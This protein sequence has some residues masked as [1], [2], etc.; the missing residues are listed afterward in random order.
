[1][2]FVGD[3]YNVSMNSRTTITLE[4]DSTYSAEDTMCL[5]EMGKSLGTW[6]LVA[7][8]TIKFHNIS[9]SGRWENGLEP[10]LIIETE[11]EAKKLISLLPIS[12]LQNHNESIANYGDS[13]YVYT[14]DR[15]ERLE[16]F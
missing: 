3:Y 7:P 10:M 6:S 5:G 8:S 16:L 15:I 13:F 12:S 11:E 2:R 1:M 4:S 9:G 14:K